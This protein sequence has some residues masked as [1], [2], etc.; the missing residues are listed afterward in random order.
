VIFPEPLRL[1]IKDV[2]VPAGRI[3]SHWLYRPERRR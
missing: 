3:G 1:A 2:Y